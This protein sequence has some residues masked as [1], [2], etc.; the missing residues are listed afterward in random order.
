MMFHSPIIERPA[1]KRSSGDNIIFIAEHSAEVRK[2]LSELTLR[3][4]S[5][6]LAP[7]LNMLNQ[8]AE[9]ENSSAKTIAAYALQLT[10]NDSKDLRTANFCKE[11]I[12]KGTFSNQSKIMSID[13]L[14]FLLDLLEIV[15]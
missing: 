13:K 4:L 6:R 7:L 3:G 2:P 14:T 1:K 5:T 15:R 12:S 9:R 11:I 10:S 8:K